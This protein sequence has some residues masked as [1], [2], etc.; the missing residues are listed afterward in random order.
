MTTPKVATFHR[1]GGR[2]YIHPS[3]GDKVPGVTTVL[4][5]MPKPFL[6]AWAAKMVATEAVEG[7]ANWQ[8]L[9][10]RDPQG[11]I[12]YLKRTPE[13]NTRE[14]ADI[15]TA[16]H[17]IF[18]SLALGETLGQIMPNLVPFARH[19]QDFLDTVQPEFLALEDTVWS[20]THGYAG[21]F[22]ALMKIQGELVWAD[23]KTT[24]S[25]VYPEVALQLSA[26]SHA[27][28]ILDGETGDTHRLPDETGRGLVVHVRPEGW[29]LYEVPIGDEIFETFLHLRQVFTWDTISRTIVG[30]PVL[31]GAAK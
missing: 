24:R 6:K 4:N 2:Y 13:R 25:G 18:E 31:K 22:D 17:G 9:A 19:Y 12:D 23:N 15:G 5:M 29:A 11:A 1:G 14:A 20:E 30:K 26:Y 16:A 10:Q 27:D 28:Y 7:L 3:S 8:P 21:S